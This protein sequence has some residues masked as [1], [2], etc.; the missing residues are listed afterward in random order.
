M[1]LSNIITYR[2]L[3]I[4]QHNEGELYTAMHSWGGFVAY[5]TVEH[6][7]AVIDGLYAKYSG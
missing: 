3:N 5:G 7:K 6:C 2:K 4:C 1:L